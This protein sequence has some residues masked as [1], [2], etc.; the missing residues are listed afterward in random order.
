MRQ[1]LAGQVLQF[2]QAAVDGGGVLGFGGSFQG[3]GQLA[4][5]AQAKAA[6]GAAQVVGFAAQ[7]FPL[8]AVCGLGDAFHPA[9]AVLDELVDEGQQPRGG[10]GVLQVLQQR[11]VEHGGGGAGGGRGLRTPNGGDGGRG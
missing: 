7:G 10:D 3:A 6:S 8:A 1:A 4:Q 11:C 5:G 2:G 9:L